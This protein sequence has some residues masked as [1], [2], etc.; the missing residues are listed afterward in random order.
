GLVGGG[1]SCASCHGGP[2]WPRSTVDFP[3]PPSP[4]VDLGL[5]DEKVIGVEL[6]QT[7]TQGPNV[8]I[9]VGTFTLGGGRL[10]EIRANPADISQAINPLGANGLNIPSLL[11]VHE[12]APYFYSGLAQTLEQVL[13]GSQ[14][15]NGGVR[16]HF[17]VDFQARADL[18]QFLRSIDDK[19]DP[20]D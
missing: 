20:I 11:S 3:P 18:I 5:G 8:L 14:D 6:R 10:N 13:D 4:D 2:K 16:H 1:F 12:T 19:T 7:D 17:V 9:N 15:G